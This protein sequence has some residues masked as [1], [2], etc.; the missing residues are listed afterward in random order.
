MAGRPVKWAET[1]T[2][3]MQT[4]SHGRGQ[5]FDI[6]VAA[7]R[8]GTLLGL[9]IHQLLDVGG[10]QGVFGA[11]QVLA[12]LVGGGCY[13]WRAVSGR[14]IGVLTNKVSTDP[15]RGAGRPEATHLVERALDLVAGKIGMDP[16]ELRR[17]NFVTSFPYT[18]P[19]GF[20][21]DSGDYS[22]TLDRALELIDYEQTRHRQAELR[23]E[24]RYL[25]IGLATYVE[26]CGFGP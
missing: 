17:R 26:I 23:R 4:T 20:V 3:T 11:V 9:K 15:Y 16:A 7:K 5:L 12:I 2:E 6:E 1:R 19:F 13:K 25:G 18:N 22:K 14:S 24:G 8:D 21:F 10:Y